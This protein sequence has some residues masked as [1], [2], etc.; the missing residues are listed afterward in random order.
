MRRTDL[1]REKFIIC[2]IYTVFFFADCGHQT[3]CLYKFTGFGFQT[4]NEPSLRK[5]AQ[6]MEANEGM[7]LLTP[8]TGYQMF[9]PNTVTSFDRKQVS[10][11]FC[12]SPTGP[13][14]GNS[15]KLHVFTYVGTLFG[16]SLSF[17]FIAI[18]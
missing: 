18:I 13:G 9:E 5:I 4:S 7:K 6:R 2:N 17:H 14:A 8:N 3:H 1:P 11:S 12:C 10:A 16:L 15:Y